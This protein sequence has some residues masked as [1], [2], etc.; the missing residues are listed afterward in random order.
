MNGPPRTGSGARD[1]SEQAAD[2]FPQRPSAAYCSPDRKFE[3]VTFQVGSSL[4]HVEREL[5]GRTIEF[6][7]RN[8]TL[9]ARMLGL[10]VRTLLSAVAALRA[11]RVG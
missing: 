8:K 1:D 7:A 10:S 5:I 9:S 11:M 3:H 2:H 6:T 4:A